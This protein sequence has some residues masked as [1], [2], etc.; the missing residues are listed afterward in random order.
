MQTQA[1]AKLTAEMEANQ[2]NSYIQAVGNFLI[3]HLQQRPEEAQF[4][5]AEDKTI[6]K[7]LDAMRKAA[8]KQKN[9]NFAMLTDAE[10]FEVVL[11]Y[12]GV[13]AASVVLPPADQAPVPK[14][15]K[16]IDFDVK[17]E[18]LL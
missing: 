14:P 18:D 12:F 9:G 10:G 11:E 1:I 5:L 7:S 6:G 17:L 15:K 2:N 8:E 4:F 16:E 3:Q 13:K